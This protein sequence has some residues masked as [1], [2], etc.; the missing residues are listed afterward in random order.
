MTGSLVDWINR[1]IDYKGIF[2]KL[3]FTWRNKRLT[4]YIKKEM[5]QLVASILKNL[6]HILH[7]Y[8]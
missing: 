1:K 5:N 8:H 6:L 4:E 3:N 7:K 2:V